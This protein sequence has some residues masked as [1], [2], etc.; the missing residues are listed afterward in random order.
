L[1]RRRGRAQRARCPGQAR[2]PRAAIA[3]VIGSSY[4]LAQ[5]E[6]ALAALQ[7]QPRT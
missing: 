4:S 5:V 7:Q 3:E 6:T 2:V 1:V